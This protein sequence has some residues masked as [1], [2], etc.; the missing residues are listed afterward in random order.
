MDG[1]AH[2]QKIK[3]CRLRDVQSCLVLLSQK[4]VDFTVAHASVSLGDE[5]VMVHAQTSVGKRH[6]TFLLGFTIGEEEA[7]KWHL[8]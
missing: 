1:S 3:N 6:E 4:R 8:C 2:A 5:L 7:L